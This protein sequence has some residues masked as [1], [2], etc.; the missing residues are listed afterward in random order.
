MWHSRPSC[1]R[2]EVEIKSAS[3]QDSRG[4]LS[5]VDATSVRGQNACPAHDCRIP[6]PPT[7]SETA[8]EDFVRRWPASAAAERANFQSFCN[9]L[10]DL[11]AVPRPDPARQDERDYAY[12]YDKT[13]WSDDGDGKRTANFI[14]LY[15]RARFVLEAKQ[16]SEADDGGQTSSNSPR[17]IA[18]SSLAADYPF[19]IT[20]FELKLII[21]A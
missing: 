4:R 21:Y 5:H 12:V 17:G 1:V 15:K 6:T 9:E 3:A 18:A 11:L 7:Q 8:I 19:P 16:G 10:C 20:I 14:D 13:V 2:P